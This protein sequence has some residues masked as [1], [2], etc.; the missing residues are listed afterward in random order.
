M[1]DV[2]G[3][4]KTL[5]SLTAL[6]DPLG[7]IPV[8][9][10]VTAHQSAQKQRITARR[11]AL[12]AFLILVIS[13]A[14]GKYVLEVFGVSVASMRVAGGILFLFM[15][16]E[17]LRAEPNRTINE[18]EVEEAEHHADVAVVPLA[19]PLLAGPGAM[20]AVILLA[21]RG[22]MWP[23]LP[24]VGI[25]VGAVMLISWVCLHLA[26]PIG[27]RLGVTGLNILNRVMGL[28]V[29]AIA[30]EF[31]VAGVKQLWMGTPS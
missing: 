5:L 14:A 9:L 18:D 6:V 31:I 3:I 24:K 26:A 10:T 23:Q 25:V 7:A 13:A 2:T 15:G 28:I 30:V 1:D 11:A 17:M 8:F 16:I 22:P 27:K 4:L 12:W 19:L 21:D 29:V 20:G